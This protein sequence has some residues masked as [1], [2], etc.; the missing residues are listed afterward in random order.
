M[1]TRR[2]DVVRPRAA[3]ERRFG[4]DQHAVAPASDSF[5]ENLFR[6][7]IRIDVGAVEHRHARIQAQIDQTSRAFDIGRTPRAKKIVP[8]AEGSRSQAQGGNE[9]SGIAEF[10]ILHARTDRAARGGGCAVRASVV[11]VR[12]QQSE[13]VY[14]GASQ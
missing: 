2:A 1:K 3:A 10:A 4:R 6:K 14:T 13:G 11:F 5:A 9:K 7:A 12:V 8:P